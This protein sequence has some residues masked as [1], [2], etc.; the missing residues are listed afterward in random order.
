MNTCKH[1]TTHTF[2]IYIQSL[3]TV[4]REIFAFKCFRVINVR[5]SN[6]HHKVQE[7]KIIHR[8]FYFR[9]LNFRR[10]QERRKIFN[11]EYFP[12][13]GTSY[14]YTKYKNNYHVQYV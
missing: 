9:V 7:V 2:C 10:P 1:K 4:D 12:I 5:V 8:V 6:F 3:S 11:G 13:Y 14:N